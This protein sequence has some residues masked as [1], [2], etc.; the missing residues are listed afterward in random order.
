MTAVRCGVLR[1]SPWNL[2]KKM[3][4]KARGQLIMA[5]AGHISLDR[6]VSAVEKV[7]QRLLR[8]TAALRKASVE[9]AVAGGNAVAAWVSTV[10]EEAVRNTADVDILVRRPDFA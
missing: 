10:D 6:M 9:Y 5:S 7:R 4:R 3:V 8:A 2:F 1:W